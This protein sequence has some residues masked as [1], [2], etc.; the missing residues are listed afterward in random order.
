MTYSISLD[1]FEI[2]EATVN[3]IVLPVSCE[4]SK[5]QPKIFYPKADVVTCNFKF[6]GQKDTRIPELAQESALPIVSAVAIEEQ[7]KKN[8]SA[9]AWLQSRREKKL[10]E[11]ELSEEK[12]EFELLNEILNEGRV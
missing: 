6:S 11:K 3:T 8:Q 1:S 9:I 5:S 12:E 10:T 2:E 4:H 7:I